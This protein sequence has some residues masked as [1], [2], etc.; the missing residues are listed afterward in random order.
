LDRFQKNKGQEDYNQN[1]A[2]SKFS[3]KMEAKELM[4]YIEEEGEEARR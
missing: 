2:E 4:Q 1:Y 3:R